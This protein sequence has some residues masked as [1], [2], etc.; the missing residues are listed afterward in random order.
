LYDLQEYP[1]EMRNVYN[2]P[3]Y[4]EVKENLHTRLDKLRAKYGDS[5]ENDQRYIDVIPKRGKKK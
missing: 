3:A 5:D 2:D 1:H 4:T